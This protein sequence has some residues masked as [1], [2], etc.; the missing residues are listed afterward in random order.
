MN[1][2]D[3]CGNHQYFCYAK[4]DKNT[5][6]TPHPWAVSLLRLSLHPVKKGSFLDGII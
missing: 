6:K 3:H 4:K 1:F 2:P 5:I